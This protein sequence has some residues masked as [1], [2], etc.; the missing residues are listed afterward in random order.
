M[1]ATRALIV[2]NAGAVVDQR[3][4]GVVYEVTEDVAE[5]YVRA[6][7]ARRYVHGTDN[8]EPVENRS[9]DGAPTDRA[10]KGR[11]KRR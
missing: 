4:P 3:Q 11:R 10:M 9:L 5:L 2:F 1:A 6:G 8:P 7:L